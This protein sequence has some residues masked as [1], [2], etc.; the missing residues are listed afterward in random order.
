MREQRTVFG[1]V[2]DVY[3]DARPGYPDEL[4]AAVLAYAGQQ[5]GIGPVVEI[6]AGTGKG[7]EAFVRNGTAVRCV[8]A[9]DRMAAVLRQ[10]FAEDPTVTVEVCRFEDWAPPAGGVG[11]LYCAQAWHW[12]DERRRCALARDAL[13]P[14]GTVA[15]FGHQYV[16]ADPAMEEAIHAVQAAVAPEIRG[17]P[18]PAGPPE[19]HWLAVELA[20]S[21]LF[22]D[23][24]AYRFDRT[25]DYPT[26]DY[27]RLVETFSPVRRG[28]TAARL[29]AFKAALAEAVDARGGVVA[30]HLDTVLALAR[31]PI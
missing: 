5:P 10:R 9:D 1:E 8:E 4:V 2:A 21:G 14:G 27:L 22:T 18:P 28:L 29:A 16:F 17:D 26:A 19:R 12:M 3:D 15:L 24:R 6:G 25:V 13:A 7:T 20:D 11:L 30:I 23:A 31:R